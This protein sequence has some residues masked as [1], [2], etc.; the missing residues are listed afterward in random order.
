MLYSSIFALLACAAHYLAPAS[1]VP[2]TH[3][4]SNATVETVYSFPNLTWVEN[5]AVRGNGK[6]LVTLIT[7]PEVWEIDPTTHTAG[8]VYSFPDA[9]AATGITEVTDDVFAVAI[10]NWSVVTAAGTKGSWSIW[11][12]DYRSRQT[13]SKHH[14]P[15]SIRKVTDIPG[16]VFLNGLTMLPTLDNTVLAG[17]SE[18]GL[19][20]RVNTH[21]GAHSVAI[22]DSAFAANATAAALLG[23]NG[24]HVRNGYLYFTNSFSASLVYG[25]IPVSSNGSATGS[26]QTIVATPPYPTNIGYHADDFALDGDGNA[27]ITTD[28]SSTLVKAA[29]GGNVTIIE[30]GLQAAV[31]AGCTS[32]AFG[33]TRGKRDTLY[34]T[35]NGGLVVPPVGGI[36]GGKVLALNTRGL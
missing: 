27:W 12:I 33:R 36:V 6:V 13:W 2:F 15:P 26:V 24:I 17:D 20:N 19:V 21:T 30:G 11:T 18:L 1:A 28:A 4:S 9:T 32:A 10:G 25:R 7:A 23:I 29:P 35:T 16:A 22:Q 8:L 31:V 3:N 34:I 5:I 14:S